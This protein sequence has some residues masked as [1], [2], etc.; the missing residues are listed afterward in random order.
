[1]QFEPAE[2]AGAFLIV[3]TPQT[4]AR[5]GFARTWCAETFR[6]RGLADALVQCSVSYNVRRGTLRG[7]HVQADPHGERKLVR[8]TTGAIYDV[9]LD[10]RPESPSFLRW[11]AFELTAANRHAV[12]IPKGVAHGFQTLTDGAEVFYQMADEFVPSSGRG[13][14]YSDPAFGIEWPLPVAVISDRDANYADFA[15][16]AVASREDGR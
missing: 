2:I 7:M 12:Y 14:R 11:Q 9:L 1:M 3:P 15:P 10:L 13:V 6:A 5:G 16:L 4:D 8:C